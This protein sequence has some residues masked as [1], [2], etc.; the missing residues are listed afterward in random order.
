ML[1]KLKKGMRLS[2]ITR[3]TTITLLIASIAGFCY[4]GVLKIIDSDSSSS[5]RV[6][7]TSTNNQKEILPKINTVRNLKS[8]IESVNRRWGNRENEAI[9][10]EKNTSDT[11]NTTAKTE[12]KSD[13]SGS[14]YSKTNVQVEGVDEGDIVKTDGQYIYKIRYNFENSLGVVDILKGF[15][16]ENASKIST[17][18]LRGRPYDL[19]LNG[20]NLVVITDMTYSEEYMTSSKEGYYEDRSRVSIQVFNIEDKSRLQIVKEVSV[21]G[22][23]LSS[24]VVENR[25]YLVTN[26][27]IYYN[28]MESKESEIQILPSYSDSARDDV[29]KTLS[30]E[31]IAYCPDALAPNYI[32]IS[33]FNLKALDEETKITAFLGQSN[34]IYCSEKNLY[35]SGYNNKE[36]RNLIRDLLGLPNKR[37]EIST[38]IYK[39]NL[40]EGDVIFEAKGSVPGAIINQFSMDECNDEFRVAT[41]RDYYKDNKGYISDNN[42]YVL[43]PDMKQNGKIE[44]IAEGERIYSTRFIGNRAY[45]VTFRNVDPLFVIDLSNGKDPEILGQLKI[46]GFSNYLHPYDENHIIGFGLDTEL[47]GSG[48]ENERAMAKGM[49]M[50]IFDVT[51][52]RNPK[53]Q[54]VEKIGDRGTYSEILYNHKALLF[55][56]NKELLAIPVQVVEYNNGTGEAKESFQGAYVYNISLKNGFELKGKIS[57]TE[58]ETVLQNQGYSWSKNVQR[59][60]FIKDYLYTI[61]NDRIMIHGIDNLSQIADIKY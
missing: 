52:I 20:N 38:A 32:I 48:T 22:K 61:S 14:D 6:V 41:T 17:Y 9:I 54:F 58:N 29:R 10:F 45:M 35:L 57:H 21:D 24:R 51:D 44:N 37:Y 33:S 1:E 53:E 18:N 42:L 46:P 60:I 3:N 28:T 19:Y 50:A 43:G 26:K 47:I 4:F 8:L 7:I 56:K 13:T 11:S 23:I 27:N 49:K 39:F 40:R 12:S 31:N 25:L 16:A 36:K 30:L 34:Q 55:D 5:S 59:I 15:P 2:K